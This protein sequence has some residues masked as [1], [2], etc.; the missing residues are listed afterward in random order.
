MSRHK[1]DYCRDSGL[2]FSRDTHGTK[3]IYQC[4]C[5]AGNHVKIEMLQPVVN[6]IQIK[7]KIERFS[8]QS[9]LDASLKIETTGIGT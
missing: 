6:G 8:P 2:V 1:C 9:G 5:E 3:K 4:F 7:T